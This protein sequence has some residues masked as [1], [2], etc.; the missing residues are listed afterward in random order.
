MTERGGLP[1]CLRCNLALVKCCQVKERYTIVSGMWDEKS[2]DVMARE[3][4]ICV[5][6]DDLAYG[7][8]DVSLLNSS[9]PKSSFGP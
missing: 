2:G 9:P 1:L 3:R 6:I 5:F 8:V 7:S 4:R